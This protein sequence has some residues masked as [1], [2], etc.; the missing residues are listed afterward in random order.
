MQSA[1]SLSADHEGKAAS[2][3]VFYEATE[4]IWVEDQ[5]GLGHECS[6]QVLRK[7]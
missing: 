2:K 1:Y 3:K 5:N 7:K 6:R 4:A